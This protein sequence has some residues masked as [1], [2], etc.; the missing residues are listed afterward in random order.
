ML[1]ETQVIFFKLC[2]TSVGLL[3]E[4]RKSIPNIFNC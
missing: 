3:C 1:V 4:N 2:L